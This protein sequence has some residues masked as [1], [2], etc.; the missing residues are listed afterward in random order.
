ME[1]FKALME[2]SAMASE[3]ALDAACSVCYFI[4]TQVQSRHRILH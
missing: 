3:L 1:T 2:E 4:S